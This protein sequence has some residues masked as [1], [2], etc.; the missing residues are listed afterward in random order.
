MAG[1]VGRPMELTFHN[2][3]WQCGYLKRWQCIYRFGFVWL[4]I[5]RGQWIAKHCLNY[6][7]AAGWRIASV[8]IVCACVRAMEIFNANLLTQLTIHTR[9]RFPF[10]FVDIASTPSEHN[11]DH[12]STK[13]T[14]WFSAYRL[15]DTNASGGEIEFI[16]SMNM[17]KVRL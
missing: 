11:G 10:H 3:L 9:L 14:L 1:S 15:T 2:V 12:K 17:V 13:F 8:S 16:F 6:L 4:A 5:T 7:Q